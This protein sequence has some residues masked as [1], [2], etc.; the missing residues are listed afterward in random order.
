MVELIDRRR[1]LAAVAG[2]AAVG[3][4][5]C[6][7]NGDDAGDDGT[8]DD[9]LGDAGPGTDPV[10]GTTETWEHFSFSDTGTYT[11]DFYA[12]GSALSSM[13]LSVLEVDD[14]QSTIGWEMIVDGQPLGG[15]NTVTAGGTAEEWDPM[16]ASFLSLSWFHP[17]AF[18]LS[19]ERLEVGDGWEQ[20]WEGETVAYELTGTDSY[21]GIDCITAELTQNDQLVYEAC[22]AEE[23]GIAVYTAFY[24]ED[25]TIAMEQTLTSYSPEPDPTVGE[26]ADSGFGGGDFGG[27]D[28]SDF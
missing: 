10:D 24:E 21:E 23:H 3:L 1:V 17:F 9:P 28:D 26:D 7:G 13:T 14:Q 22:L 6:S 19:G 18:H 2:S 15:Q 20:T 25:G 8:D 4:A 16:V 11:F 5:G 12:E 27:E